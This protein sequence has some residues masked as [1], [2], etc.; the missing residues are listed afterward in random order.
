VTS[1]RAVCVK[2]YAM[3]WLHLLKN[4]HDKQNGGE[5]SCA[6]E[7]TIGHLEQGCAEVGPRFDAAFVNPQ[8]GLS[9]ALR[10]LHVV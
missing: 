9:V 8:L 4:K 6:P 1:I 10:N 7:R 5:E 3:K 2:H